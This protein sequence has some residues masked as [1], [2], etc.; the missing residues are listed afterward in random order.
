[1]KNNKAKKKAAEKVESKVVTKC[2]NL[3]AVS[4]NH[5][6]LITSVAQ[7]SPKSVSVKS[8]IRVIRGQQVMLY[9]DLTLLYGIKIRRLNEQFKRYVERF[10]NDF[11][12]QLT[13]EFFLKSQ[14]AI[15]NIC[16]IA[17]KTIIYEQ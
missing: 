9:S 13:K 16:N 7:S 12:F 15:S 3:N 17:K 8:M 6:E 11:L 14:F 4:Q 5:D 10:L 2:D 1:M